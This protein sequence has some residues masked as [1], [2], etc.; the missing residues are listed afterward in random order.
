MYILL[1]GIYFQGPK[2]Q[3]DRELLQFTII[4]DKGTVIIKCRS[5]R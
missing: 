2:L 3:I 5:D 1:F 4:T